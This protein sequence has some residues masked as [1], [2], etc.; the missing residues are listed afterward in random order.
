MIGS[1]DFS[2]RGRAGDTWLPFADGTKW[3]KYVRTSE[4][5]EHA[6]STTGIVR[7]TSKVGISIEAQLDLAGVVANP[8]MQLD[9]LGGKKVTHQPVHHV[10]TLLGPLS[11]ACGQIAGGT[12]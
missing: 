12:E 6:R 11:N 4:A 8:A 7:I 1:N 10:I 3:H 5:K 9:I 2:F